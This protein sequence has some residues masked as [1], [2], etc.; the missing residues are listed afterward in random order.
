MS[1]QEQF[2]LALERVEPGDV[3]PVMLF[4]IGTFKSAKYPELPLTRDLA[5]EVIANFAGNVL[6]TEPV[7]DTSG[8]HDTSAPAGAWVKRV[9]VSPTKDGGEAAFADVQWTDIGA[10]KVNAREY[11]YNSVELGPVVDN[12]TGVRTENVLR[13]VT[14]TNTPV[15]R[16][17]PKLLEAG[18]VIAEPVELALSEVT[19]AGEAP[20]PSIEDDM[21][22]LAARLDET[23]KGRR[24]VPVIRTL[25]REA[26][27]K[28]RTHSLSEDDGNPAES[29]PASSDGVSQPAKA[30]EGQPVA[31]A[32]GDAAA[33]GVDPRMKSVIQKLQLSEDADES[34]I[35]AAVVT[36]SEERDSEK[37]RADAAEARLAEGERA[38][39]TAAVEAQLSELIDGGHLLPGQKDE[40]LA[41]A[42]DSPSGFDRAVAVLKTSKA[43]ELGE[44]G[45]S[46]GGD[47]NTDPEEAL[48]VKAS[49]IAKERGVDMATALDLA[50]SE[51]PTIADAYKATR[52]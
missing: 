35:L 49:E 4:P 32:E 52:I 7:V 22:A 39:R 3:T 25:L 44:A 51:N 11:Q 30:D 34:A 33:K 16:I 21:L 19:A 18:D 13:S 27:A 46:E 31:L 23:L 12:V 47:A 40:M 29:H 17:L 48:T 1:I 24:G 20:Q 14:L 41:L 9:Y 15:I 37:T 2:K 26:F 50:L 8:K 45:T 5:D 10:Q 38:A 36:L 6:G 42:E 28:V 43:L